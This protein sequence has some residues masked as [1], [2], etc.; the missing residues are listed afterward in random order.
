MRRVSHLKPAHL[1]SSP[2]TREERKS[3]N[4]CRLSLD[5]SK[6]LNL[7]AWRLPVPSSS[8]P[9]NPHTHTPW[10]SICRSLLHAST[11]RSTFGVLWFGFASRRRNKPD[12]NL[13][14]L[15]DS[16]PL[17]A[18]ALAASFWRQPPPNPPRSH[19]PTTTDARAAPHFPPSLAMQSSSATGLTPTLANTSSFFTNG[20]SSPS[21]PT[22][23]DGPSPSGGGG[24]FFG[25]S[26]QPQP[27]GQSQA[28]DKERKSS[29][30]RRSSLSSSRRRGSTSTPSSSNAVI[31][32]A[33]APPALPDYA[34]SAAVKI[35]PQKDSH[36]GVLS[37]VSPDTIPPN[38]APLSTTSSNNAG[39]MQP[40]TTSAMPVAS[41]TQW[42]QSEAAM[43]HQQIVEAAHK[44]ISTLTY[45]RKA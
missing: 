13:F 42:H 10:R 5:Q 16:F 1:S 6:R 44:R 31:T 39:S 20:A 34:L 8:K 27:P 21:R 38:T 18:E 17:G 26:S 43:I 11:P 9:L 4:E 14:A 32:D 24:S 25:G 30:S 3:K 29:F 2:C 35:V 15:C 37:P 19:Q 23:R 36:D 12:C 45:M 28:K 41:P 22:T 40:L 7:L 33:A